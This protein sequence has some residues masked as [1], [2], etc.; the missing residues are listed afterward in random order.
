MRR[1]SSVNDDADTAALAALIPA[2]PTPL[3]GTNTLDRKKNRHCDT[4]SSSRH[5]PEDGDA[6]TL[7]IDSNCFSGFSS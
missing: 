2:D 7:L 5:R 3:G 4:P 1:R 6:A